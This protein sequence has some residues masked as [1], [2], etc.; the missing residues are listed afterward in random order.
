MAPKKSQP[1]SPMGVLSMLREKGVVSAGANFGKKAATVDAFGAPVFP[2]TIETCPILLLAFTERSPMVPDDFHNVERSGKGL[3]EYVR[4]DGGVFLG[5]FQPAGEKDG[6]V[7]VFGDPAMSQG[8]AQRIALQY[9][10]QL[11]ERYEGHCAAQALGPFSGL[12]VAAETA[13]AVSER[14]TP[15]A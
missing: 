14:E 12:P 4:P 11:I 13:P 1:Y 3:R 7:V 5:A 6:V 10:Q 9:R 8:A 15:P 2:K